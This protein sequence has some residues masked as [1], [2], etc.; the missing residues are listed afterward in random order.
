MSE[1]IHRDA[2]IEEELTRARDWAN[3]FIIFDDLASFSRAAETETGRVFDFASI[4]RLATDFIQ[5]SDKYLLVNIKES[6]GENNLLL[7]TEEKGYA[8]SKKPLSLESARTFSDVLPK[9]FGRSTILAFLILDKAL[10]SYKQQ[11]ETFVERGRE[12][13]EDFDYLPYR[14]L[15]MDLERFND[16]LEGFHDVLLRLQGSKYKQ[17][18][19]HYIAFDYD[20]LI[21][22]SMGLQG[23][24]RRRLAVLID[25]RQDH[26]MRATEELNQKI[27]KLNDVVKK[28]TALTVILMLPTLIASHFGMNF[29]YMPELKIWWVYPAV[30]IS[31]L[32]LMVAGFMWFRKIRWL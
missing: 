27:V 24:G 22:E 8:F 13:E 18:E 6:D 9:A 2:K 25:I 4:T 30:I 12:L 20:V 23:R 11:L 7:L 17:V 26:D 5:S 31:Q 29:A 3:E 28:L 32:V 15:A 16:R 14:N 21:A 19:T 1:L 10:E